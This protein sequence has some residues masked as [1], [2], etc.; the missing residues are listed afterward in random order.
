MQGIPATLY[1]TSFLSEGSFNLCLSITS[2]VARSDG[3]IVG[4]IALC[5]VVCAVVRYMQCMFWV[6][7]VCVCVCVCVCV[8]I[9]M[10][11]HMCVCLWVSEY[12]TTKI[13][14]H[15][16]GGSRGGGGTQGPFPPSASASE[17]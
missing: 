10:Y 12:R 8:Y 4:N 1:L 5:A 7:V 6:H 16:R 2:S 13:T 11:I 14:N 3:Y 17:A 9:I 15:A